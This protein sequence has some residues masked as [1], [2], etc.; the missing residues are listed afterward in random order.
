M[1]AGMSIKAVCTT[2]GA[3]SVRQ[4]NNNGSTLASILHP[5]DLGGMADDAADSTR[6]GGGRPET[7]GE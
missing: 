2:R 1:T 3:S 5:A 4:S 6:P 7:D